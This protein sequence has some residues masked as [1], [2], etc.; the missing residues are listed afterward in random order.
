MANIKSA[1]KRAEQSK[2]RRAHN[3]SM[4]SAFRTKIKKI[5][6]LI[7]S[8]DAKGARQLFNDSVGFLDSFVNKHLATANKV[9]RHKSRL[10]A[11]I[12]ALDV[13]S[14]AKAK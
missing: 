1:K 14:A 8:R 9:A 12:K 10:S 7:A 11:K 6:Q 13:G 3:L 4:Q 5:E 2:V